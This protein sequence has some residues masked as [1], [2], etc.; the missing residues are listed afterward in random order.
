MT[1]IVERLTSEIDI[2]ASQGTVL[3][4]ED[5]KAEIK[6]LRESLTYHIAQIGH[7][8]MVER[9]RCAG[10]AENHYTDKK[11]EIAAAIRESDDATVR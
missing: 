10:I 5:A 9:E 3:V 6:R 7:A 8:T 2:A 4:L 1:D 11:Y